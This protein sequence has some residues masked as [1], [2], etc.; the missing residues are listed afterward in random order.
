M[1]SKLS[2][3]IIL[4]INSLYPIAAQQRTSISDELQVSKLSN[5]VYLYTSYLET[6]EFGKVGA[7]GLII[8]KNDKAL[9]IDTPW[10]NSQTEILDQWVQDSLHATVNTLVATHWHDDCMGGLEYLQSK[11]VNSYANAMTIEISE[12]K[13]LPIP[14]HGFVDSLEI[15][16]EQIP[17]ECYFMGAGH[18][19][20]NI[21]V[22]LPTQD[23]LFGGCCIKDLSSVNLGNLAD[24]DTQAWPSTITRIS[25]KFSNVK[26]IVPGHGGAGDNQLI[27]HTMEL[28]EK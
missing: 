8:V 15:D 25:H 1:K 13:G 4:M 23:I 6:Q 9:L 26:I 14:Q 22:W 18:S 21:V 16:F 12:E 19:S 20:D 3:L 28:L 7:N 5:N 10:N 27:Q 11:G 24:A 2:I 17:V